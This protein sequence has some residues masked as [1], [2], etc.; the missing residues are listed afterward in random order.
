MKTVIKS[1][2][3]C[4][5]RFPAPLGEVNRGYGKFCS[6]LCSAQY[7]RGKKKY[8]EP[9]CECA[10][11]SQMFYRPASK[12][13]RSKSGLHFCCRAHKDRAQR[14]GG[15]EEIMPPH[16]GTASNDASS[17]YRKVAFD[18]Y[19]AECADCGYSK[20]PTVLE[21]HHLDGDRAN[22]DADN[23][24]ILCPTCHDEW[25]YVSRTGKWFTSTL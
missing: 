12:R 8:R 17:Q 2:L 11:C 18:T 5:R 9:N 22:I 3:H 21:V 6:M 24:R 7:R 15:I 10:L 13:I 1:C 25:H 19:L 20:Y 16:Y 14:I 23:L 4:S